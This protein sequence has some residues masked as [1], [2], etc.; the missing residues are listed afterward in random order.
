LY[1]EVSAET[2]CRRAVVE[3]PLPSFL[4]TVGAVALF[5]V[6]H[7]LLV[8]KATDP[9]TRRFAT[10]IVWTVA[11]LGTFGMF[12]ANISLLRAFGT[13][14]RAPMVVWLPQVLLLAIA[15]VIAGRFWRRALPAAHLGSY[16]VLGITATAYVSMYAVAFEGF[17]SGVP[18]VL[19]WTRTVLWAV[20]LLVVL[21]DGGE[22]EVRDG[23][24]A[25]PA[26]EA[27][28]G[29]GSSVAPTGRL[30]SL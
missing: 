21:R 3:V 11:L 14:G 28:A 19:A 26:T 29:E 23:H 20:F 5:V 7:A 15:F 8:E 27:S 13:R 30:R 25:E 12:S 10:A 6:L 17:T 4:L 22:P 1:A 9:S 24:A 18:T 2:N 16:V